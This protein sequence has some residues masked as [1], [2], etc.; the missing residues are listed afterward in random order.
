MQGNARLTAA[1]LL[2]AGLGLAPTSASAAN[3]IIRD[4]SSHS[5]PLNLDV[6]TGLG[7]WGGGSWGT[8]VYLGIPIVPDGFIPKLNDSFSIEASGRFDYFWGYCYVGYRGCGGRSSFGLVAGV[9]WTFYLTP[10]WA[11]YGRING[12][13]G[14][15][16]P[17]TYDNRVLPRFESDSGV[18]A[19]WM[20]SDAAWMRFDATVRGFAVGMGF[21]LGT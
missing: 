19:Y 16:L 1:V 9:K 2:T 6:T 18:G 7:W 21:P 10:D 14:L 3:M 4:S 5:R 20:F 12:G 11:V 15:R 13:L 17:V 8:A